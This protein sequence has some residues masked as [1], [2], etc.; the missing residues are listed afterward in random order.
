MLFEDCYN[1]ISKPCEGV[2]KD[3]GSKFIACA[4]PFTNEEN[5]KEILT[6][7]KSEH[8]KARH[9]CYAYRLS[10]DRTVFRINDDGEPP[11][12]AGRPILNTL[13]SKE[14]TNVLIIVVRY[15]GGTLLGIPGLIHAYKSATEDVIAQAQIIEK[16]VQDI[17]L[18][19]F[20][21]LQMNDIMSLIKEENLENFDQEFD[22]ACKLKIAVNQSEVN[23]IID[24][25][26]TIQNIKTQYIKTI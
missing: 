13:L 21:Y 4:F 8:P 26:V 22:L 17:Y 12:T 9:W 7:V 5:L 15:F 3:K 23:R 11:G 18:I 2:F 14:I 20:E 25:L 6:K 19:S 10:I 16:T 24:K 1:T